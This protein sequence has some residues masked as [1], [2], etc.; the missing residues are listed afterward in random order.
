MYVCMY[1][2]VYVCM[3]VYRGQ[4]RNIHYIRGYIDNMPS[5]PSQTKEH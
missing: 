3:Y 5:Y 4:I 2:C 1:V